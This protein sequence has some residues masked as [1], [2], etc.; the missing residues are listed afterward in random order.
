MSA[1]SRSMIELRL[2][3]ASG[4]GASVGRDATGRVVFAMGG[5]PGEVVRVALDS[6]KKRFARGNVVEVLESADGRVVP[7]CATAQAGCGGCDLSH[8]ARELQQ[9]MKIVVVADALERIAKIDVPEIIGFRSLDAMAYR[10]TVRAAVTNGRAGYRRRASHDAVAASECLVAH[11]RVEEL[12]VDGRWGSAHEVTIRAS[13]ATGERLAVVDGPLEG[14][15]IPDDVAKVAA[16][17]RGPGAPFISERV[18]ERDWRIS[19]GSF[20]QSGPAAA[21]ALVDVV[22]VAA[23][24][25]TGRTMLDAYAGVGLF[26]GSV[27]QDAR[28]VTAVEVSPSSVADAR[29]NLG[30]GVEIHECRVESWSA[31]PTDVVI[32]DPARA[33]LGAEALDTLLAAQPDRFVLVSCDAGSMGRDIGLLVARGFQLESVEIVDA[34]AD[35]SHVEVVTALHR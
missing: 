11:P 22:G 14:L 8:A 6:E 21:Q 26:A 23:G 9:E 18:A 16:P 17:A 13:A 20:F 29:I 3:A 31:S 19:A 5:L 30:P 33:G 15:T 7:A 2:D 27:G 28:A 4:G 10:T 35:T 25:L 32:A 12:L 24:D 34:F 1:P